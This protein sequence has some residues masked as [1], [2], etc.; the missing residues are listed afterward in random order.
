MISDF[1]PKRSDRFAQTDIYVS[2]RTFLEASSWKIF[3][4][5][6]GFWA[7]NFGLRVKLV[8]QGWQNCIFRAQRKIL[9]KA[10]FWKK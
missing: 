3:I 5:P 6:F 4:V 10:K 9:V 1:E 8:R 2:R 7:E